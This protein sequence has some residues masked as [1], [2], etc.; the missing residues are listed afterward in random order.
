MLEDAHGGLLA[1]HLAEKRVYD[2][3]RRTYWLQGMCADVRKHCWSCLA[4]A[5][6]R[7]TG[8]ASRPPLQLIP[9]GGPFR[10]VG[11]N[12]L[13]LPQ[14]YDGNQYVVVFLDYLTKWVEAFPVADQRAE[15]V[16]RL[17]TEEVICRHGAPE[18]LL[19]DRGANFLS[20][21]MAEVCRFM[22]VKKVNTLGYHPQTDGLVERLH[23]TLIQMLSLWVEKHGRDWDHYLPYLLYAY[24]V[25][26]QESVH[27]SPFFLLYGRDPRQPTAKALSCPTT[28]Y[29]V[30]TDDYKSEL[31]HGLSDAWKAAAHVYQNCSM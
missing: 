4:C 8:K 26:A 22:K 23:Q 17:L 1:G 30:D 12:I 10:T 21:L 2:R 27:E 13:K 16:V 14:T 29:V 20:D 5:T 7:G 31:V 18:R 25:S 15:T 11:I 6:R 19:S 9:V 28:P 24:R 3:L